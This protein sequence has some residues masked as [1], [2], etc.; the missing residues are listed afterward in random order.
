M[1]KAVRLYAQVLVDVIQAP[2]AGAASDVIAELAQF[3]SLTQES[4]MFLKVLDNPTISEEDKQKAL[5]GIFA[6]QKVSALS[7]RFIGMLVKR[8]RVGILSDIL[9]EIESIQVAKKGGV[10]GELVSAIPLEAGVV[11]T[12]AQALS[13][14]LNKNV[15]LKEKVDPSLIAG[16]RVTLG[17]VTYDGSVQNRLEK[18][19][20][21]LN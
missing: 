14:K 12:V 15:Q 8:N 11:S 7:E 1:M 5:K 3:S 17:G 2:G 18:L 10:M 21:N 19:A 20:G 13:K 9:S 6:K 16:M 4:A